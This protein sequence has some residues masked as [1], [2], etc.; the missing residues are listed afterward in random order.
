MSPTGSTTSTCG[1]ESRNDHPSGSI[2]ARITPEAAAAGDLVIITGSYLSGATFQFT[3]FLVIGS[4][5]TPPYLPLPIP[6]APLGNTF[7]L[8]WLESDGLGGL[9]VSNGLEITL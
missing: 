6:L 7:M 1:F 3:A 4:P 9:F 8:Q 2:L 5:A